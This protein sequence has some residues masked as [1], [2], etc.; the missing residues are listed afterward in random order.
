[1]REPELEIKQATSI[2]AEVD[3][4]VAADCLDDV[5]LLAT[6][7]DT[8][9]EINEVRELVSLSRHQSIKSSLEICRKERRATLL[10]AG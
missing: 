1:M 8:W 5:D 9:D 2:L 10:K 4:M 6:V 3:T 7:A